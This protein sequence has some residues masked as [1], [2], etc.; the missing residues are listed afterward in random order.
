MILMY[1]DD[2]STDP[3]LSGSKEFRLDPFV[4]ELVSLPIVRRLETVV[5]FAFCLKKNNFQRLLFI[6][7]YS[8]AQSVTTFTA[9]VTP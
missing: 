6:F 4:I 8:T 5:H 1:A 9:R 3:D 2:L 7:K